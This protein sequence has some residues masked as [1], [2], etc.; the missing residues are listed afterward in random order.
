MTV[1][2]VVSDR[3]T[4]PFSYEISGDPSTQ[5]SQVT[6]TGPADIMD[7][8][9]R[10]KVV[11]PFRGARSTVQEDRT[12]LFK[13]AQGQVLTGL[14]ADPETVQVTVPISQSFNTRDAAVHVVITGTVAPGYW[15]SN[16]TV[17]PDTVTLLGPQ[18]ILEQIGG[19]V[20]TIPVDVVARPVIS[21]AAFRWRRLPE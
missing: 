10:A 1:A 14:T 20:D 3:D 5:P 17:D 19:F 21:C 9:A 12:V 8:L 4:L 7:N 16:I 13:D 2:V 11:L 6:V 15:I 18:A